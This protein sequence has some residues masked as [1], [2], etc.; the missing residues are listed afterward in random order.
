MWPLYGI[1]LDR[2]HDRMAQSKTLLDAA[3]LSFRRWPACDW[4]DLSPAEIEEAT[5]QDT[6]LFAKKRVTP[7][8]IA[9]FLS[10]VKLWC[11]IAT[12]DAA[13]AV[14]LE[15]DFAFGPEAADILQRIPGSN[16]QHPGPTGTTSSRNPGGGI[17]SE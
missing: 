15:D 3:G 5:A 17:I 10:H 7:P 16:Q 14:V 2:A 8:E 6:P 11:E 12:G 1:N 13:R 9:C 4:R